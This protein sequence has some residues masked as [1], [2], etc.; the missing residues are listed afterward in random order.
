MRGIK[1]G[2]VERQ[3]ANVARMAREQ[4]EYCERKQKEREEMS[5][6]RGAKNKPKV[7]SQGEALAEAL[8]FVSVA[9][10]K[11]DEFYKEH[12]RLS[13]NFAV[14]FD[15]QIAAG[16][17]IAEELNY[18]AHLG[19]LR[20][21]IAKCGASLAIAELPTGRLSIKGEK[22]RALV[23]CLP[24]DEMPPAYPDQPCAVIDDR[25]KEA[26]KVCNAL[27]SEAADRVVCASLLLEA[28]QCT[29]TNGA[30]LM[31]YWHGIDLPPHIVLPKLFA[32]A[33]LKINKPLTGF[34]FSWNHD[35]T[36]VASVTFWFDGG[37]WIKT[38]CYSDRWPSVSNIVD[39]PSYPT[40]LPEGLFEAIE[41]VAEFNDDGY[42]TLCENMVQSHRNVEVGAQYQVD[43]LQ[44]GKQFDG[45]LIKQ[46]R[47]FVTSIDLTTYPDRAYFN[48]ENMRGVLMTLK[49]GSAPEEPKPVVQAS[50]AWGTG[51][52]FA[53]AQDREPSGTIGGAQIVGDDDCEIDDNIPF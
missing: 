36:Q 5:R 11:D 26:F 34:G 2:Y 20:T 43:G 31:Q 32:S 49:D 17:P 27:A 16:H 24:A 28:N 44:G 15:G 41:A 53:A 1:P 39:V 42:V 18:C 14:A 38:Q 22:I 23:P 40:N 9:A 33:V 7:N 25:I 48:G 21:A 51:A 29:G 19:Q 47:Q 37:C 12:V 52:A 8:A 45:K 6:P 4:I 3:D 50:P 46:V 30:A 35:N 13:N 10:T